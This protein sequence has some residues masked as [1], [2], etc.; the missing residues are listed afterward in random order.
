M[1]IFQKLH[2]VLSFKDIL[3]ANFKIKTMNVGVCGHNFAVK[4]Q[5]RMKKF[6]LNCIDLSCSFVL[7][8]NFKMRIDCF[9]F[10]SEGEHALALSLIF[11]LIEPQCSCKMWCMVV[12]GFYS[13]S[14]AVPPLYYLVPSVTMSLSALG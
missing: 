2:A 10:L 6:L 1:Q 8:I 7:L 14:G 13:S 12:D 11:G 5:T 9:N 3:P 4:F